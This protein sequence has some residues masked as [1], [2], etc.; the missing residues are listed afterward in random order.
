MG[1]GPMKRAIAASFLMLAFTAVSADSKAQAP[2]PPQVEDS[3]FKAGQAELAR[4]LA[5]K[6]VTGPAKNVIL[7]VGDGMGVSTIR[8]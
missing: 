2:H 5:V 4:R 8:T 3:Y 6:P 1:D 7:F